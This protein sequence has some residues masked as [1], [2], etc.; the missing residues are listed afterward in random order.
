MTTYT[1]DQLAEILANHS[2]WL[3]SVRTEVSD[4]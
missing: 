3:P 2:K 4:E 1:P